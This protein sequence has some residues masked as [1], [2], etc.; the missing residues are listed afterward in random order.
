MTAGFMAYVKRKQLTHILQAIFPNSN[1][2]KDFFRSLPGV[3]TYAAFF[4]L[5][6]FTSSGVKH[7]SLRSETRKEPISPSR[8]IL[9]CCA[10]RGIS[11]TKDARPQ[12]HQAGSWY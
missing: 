11:I 7:P 12:S 3:N 8:M 1:V 5:E 9:I 10:C 2:F 4:I 6:A